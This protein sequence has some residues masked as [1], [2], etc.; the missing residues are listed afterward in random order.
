[1]YI[2]Y[3]KQDKMYATSDH[4]YI[5]HFCKTLV[6]IEAGLFWHGTVSKHLPTIQNTLATKHQHENY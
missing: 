3:Y 5:F 6:D 4:T 2:R 1:M